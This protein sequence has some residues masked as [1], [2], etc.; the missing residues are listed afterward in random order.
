MYSFSRYFLIGFFV[1]FWDICISL[2]EGQRGVFRN[3]SWALKA[4]VAHLAKTL[5]LHYK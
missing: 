5:T 3:L 2:Q 4:Y 1:E